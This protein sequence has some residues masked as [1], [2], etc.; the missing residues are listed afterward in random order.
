MCQNTDVFIMSLLNKG[1][2]FLG[3]GP[4]VKLEFSLQVKA[5]K[6]FSRT[7]SDSL[8]TSITD[9]TDVTVK[10]PANQQIMIDL[11]RRKVDI[12][13]RWRGLFTLLGNYK[14]RFF[15]DIETV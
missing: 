11:L 14:I 2:G 13:Y 9:K 10:V 15:S 8:T 1:F 7:E 6:S 4:K 12:T 3:F 5:S